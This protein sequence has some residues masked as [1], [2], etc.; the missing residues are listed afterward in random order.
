M[1]HAPRAVNRGRCGQRGSSGSAQK[2]AAQAATVECGRF[3]G[4]L[5]AHTHGALCG[6]GALVGDEVRISVSVNAP[7]GAPV[8]PRLLV[9]DVQCSSGKR[10]RHAMRV[11][12]HRRRCSHSLWLRTYA[13]G[14][15]RWVY[16]NG[17]ALQRLWQQRLW[18]QRR[19]WR[20]LV[21]D[22]PLDSRARGRAAHPGARRVT[23]MSAHQRE[24]RVEDGYSSLSQRQNFRCACELRPTEI[25][26]RLLPRCTDR[27]LPRCTRFGRPRPSR[28][29]ISTNSG[30]RCMGHV[31]RTL[32]LPL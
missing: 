29:P 25:T 15:Q 16:R 9:R 12:S 17:D 5:H 7:E 13:K 22:A 30:R 24:W 27:L 14:G 32:P 10:H 8:S 18:L 20:W 6:H 19:R 4:G 3:V 31:D 23:K 11:G 26:G 2:I 28:R 1:R 21:E